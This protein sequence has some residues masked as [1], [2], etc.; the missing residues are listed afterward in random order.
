MYK[1]PVLAYEMLSARTDRSKIVEIIKGKNIKI[2]RSQDDA[3][4]IDG[5]PF[6]MGKELDISIKPLS[7][8][9]IAPNY[10]S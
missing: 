7:L 3:I 9:I 6:F 1:L 10:E 4:H 5:E 2:K 8:N